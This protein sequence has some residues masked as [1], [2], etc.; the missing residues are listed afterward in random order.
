MLI[1]IINGEHA[2]QSTI[3]YLFSVASKRQTILV[4]KYQND[5]RRNVH[6][7]WRNV[8]RHYDEKCRC[9]GLKHI[10]TDSEWQR[11]TARPNDFIHPTAV[12]NFPYCCTQHLSVWVHVVLQ[13][14]RDQSIKHGGDE[15]NSYGSATEYWRRNYDSGSTPLD[16][17]K[18]QRYINTTTRRREAPITYQ[19][20]RCHDCKSTFGCITKVRV[21]LYIVRHVINDERIF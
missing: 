5:E 19:D 16:V 12:R 8:N 15:I 11:T 20:S 17:R 3:N 10:A 2:E 7:V 1:I 18:I 21:I 9:A 14:S 13:D 6:F 4:F